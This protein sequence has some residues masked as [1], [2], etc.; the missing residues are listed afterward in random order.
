MPGKTA[1]YR[2]RARRIQAAWWWGAAAAVIAGMLVWLLPLQRE[3]GNT[4]PIASTA[5]KTPASDNAQQMQ[6]ATPAKPMIRITL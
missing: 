5:N 6:K 1:L 3:A 2:N 4:A